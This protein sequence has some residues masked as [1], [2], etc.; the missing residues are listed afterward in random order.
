MH[1]SGIETNLSLWQLLL[2]YQGETTSGRHCLLLLSSL[3]PLVLIQKVVAVLLSRRTP[4]L[5]R[6]P[7][8]KGNPLPKE[9]YQ[10]E[11]GTDMDVGQRHPMARRKP[12]MN[13]RK[14]QGGTQCL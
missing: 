7:P 10:R 14:L 13:A 6:R 4:T 9:V 3:H 12:E 11:A 8:P 5:E 2:A 1:Q